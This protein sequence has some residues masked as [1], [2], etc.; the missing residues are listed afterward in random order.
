M[1]EEADA[2]PGVRYRDFDAAA[3]ERQ[4]VRFTIGERQYRLPGIVPA[5]LVLMRMRS[6]YAEADLIE[7]QRALC[8]DENVDQMLQDG[9][10]IEQMV[11]LTLWLMDEYNIGGR[12]KTA[13]D[14]EEGGEDGPTDPPPA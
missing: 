6:D 11:E 13:K 3:D 14:A 9:V 4:P 1:P 8:G 7:W 10:S 2:L 5:R 12:R